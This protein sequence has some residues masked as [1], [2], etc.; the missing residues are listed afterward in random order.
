MSALAERGPSPK[1]ERDAAIGVVE[2]PL[3]LIDLTDFTVSAISTA[4]LRRLGVAPSAV[5]GLPVTNQIVGA[6]RAA[7]L[8]ALRA[9]RAGA[10]DF[11]R[12]HRRVA[13][14]TN[15]GRDMTA[16]VR[17]F[18]F[19]DKPV[20]LA[21]TAPGDASERSPIATYLGR[22]PLAMAVGTVDRD[23]SITSVS[24]DIVDLIGI[25]AAETVG[26]RLTSDVPQTD[27]HLLLEASRQASADRSV[28]LRLRLRSR[29]GD[30]IPLCCLL[31][32]LAGTTELCFILL[33]YDQQDGDDAGTEG[34]AAKLEHHLWRIA[35]E[36]H[37]SGVMDLGVPL[38]DGS[39]LPQAGELT[40]RQLEIL[41]R[42]VRGER[43]PTIARELYIS[44]STVRNHLA[45]IFER[46]DVHSQAELLAKVAVERPTVAA[47]R[48]DG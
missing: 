1:H 41:R 13:D 25:T 34:R 14:A 10:V 19:G 9:L 11:Y 3:L 24:A 16:W 44:Q 29:T 48:P 45:A 7:T 2:L 31:T 12:A 38:A 32:S 33:R 8:R 39:A 22:E 26:Q 20:A 4:A 36:L 6:D 27:I 47:A 46:F 40:P 21:E 35:V 5:L 30:W 15:T 42:L 18:L 43:V 37:A 17:P 28:A 23:W